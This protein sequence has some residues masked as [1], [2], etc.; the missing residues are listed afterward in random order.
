MIVKRSIHTHIS[1][2]VSVGLDPISNEYSWFFTFSRDIKPSDKG[3]PHCVVTHQTLWWIGLARLY[4]RGRRR[5]RHLVGRRAAARQWPARA[6]PPQRHHG[7]SCHIS[8]R[9]WKAN[10]VSLNGYDTSCIISWCFAGSDYIC[11][12]DPTTTAA[13]CRQPGGGER[14]ASLVVRQNHDPNGQCRGE[15]GNE[16]HRRAA[17]FARRPKLYIPITYYKKSNLLSLSRQGSTEHICNFE[18]KNPTC[19]FQIFFEYSN[20]WIWLVSNFLIFSLA[21]QIPNVN[22]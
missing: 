1:I 20:I 10:E 13:A 15:P 18:K 21:K 17:A 12:Y 7:V 14:H 5:R 9:R 16:I 11:S 3:S 8:F 6:A 4:A 22:I 2:T 19:S